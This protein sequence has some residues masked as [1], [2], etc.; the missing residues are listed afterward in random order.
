MWLSTLNSKITYVPYIFHRVLILNFPW[1]IHLILRMYALQKNLQPVEVCAKYYICVPQ[2]RNTTRVLLK[3]FQHILVEF[4]IDCPRSMLANMLVSEV[5]QSCL[6]LGDPM[7]CSLPG[8]SVHRIF[9]ARVLE[10]WPRDWTRVS[11]IVGRRFT[12]WATREVPANM[13][14]GLVSGFQT[15]ATQT[16]WT[17]ARQAP[18]SMGIPRQ[19]YQSGY[20]ALL[21]G[22][23]LTQGLNPCLLYLLPWQAGSL[24]LAPLGKPKY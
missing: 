19:E 8:S 3:R 14:S 23:F 4:W 15:E 7:D 10:S 17:V 11:H 22:I 21:Q 20:C 16:P 1:Y 12:I 9:Q 5:A 6:T 24:P 18:L 2:S 13:L